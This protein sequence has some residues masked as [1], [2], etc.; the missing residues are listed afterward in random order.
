M[1]GV[2]ALGF[3]VVFCTSPAVRQKKVEEAERG[4]D[5]VHSSWYVLRREG[6]DTLRGRRWML[7]L[8]RPTR[9]LVD[10]FLDLGIKVEA[11]YVPE[12]GLWGEVGAGGYVRDTVYRGVPVYSLYGKR[13]APAPEELRK[14]DAILFALRDVGVRYYTYLSTLSLVLRAAAQAQKPVWV[15][16]FP[17]PH[18]HYAYGPLLDSSLFSFVG[19]HATPLVLGLTIGEYARLLVGEGWVPPCALRVVPWRG[20]QR[21][22]AALSRWAAE[23]RAFWQEAP[24]PALQSPE[25]IHLY[26]ILG[27][28]DA[29]S[30]VSVG[31]GLNKAFTLIGWDPRQ[32]S[33]LLPFRD[34]VLYGYRLRA[35]EFVPRAGARQGKVCAGWQIEPPDEVK[36]DS[37]FRLGFTLLKAAYAASGGSEEVF[38][39]LEFFDKLTGTP[40]VRWYVERGLSVAQMYGDFRAPETWERLRARYQLYP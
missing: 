26:P 17:N 4:V 11:V 30:A 23:A 5:S 29:S 20:W 13:R 15:L 19:L 16:D 18:A 1:R 14:A 22:S 40:L 38:G 25:A 33:P 10:S 3:I 37:L 36:P 9:G 31:R 12:H 35:T 8:H 39:D 21:N 2:L 34:T 7:V 28:Y 6:L 24:S 27:W 32:E